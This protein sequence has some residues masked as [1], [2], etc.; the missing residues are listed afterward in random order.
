M[1]SL[2]Y[3]LVSTLLSIS[4]VDETASTI[5]AT[6]ESPT[7]DDMSLAKSATGQL[8][9]K[10]NSVLQ[11]QDDFDGE[12]ENF[13]AQFFISELA[14]VGG[15]AVG[16][17][18]P[19]AEILWSIGGNTQRRLV[20]VYN[21]TAVTG[22]AEH[23]NIRV[24]DDTILT[25]ISNQ[26]QYNMSVT[27]ARGVRGSTALPPIYQ[28]YISNPILTAFGMFILIPGATFVLPIPENAGITSV[29]VTASQVGVL[30]N[31]TEFTFSQATPFAALKRYNPMD[32]GFVPLSSQ[33]T[34]L[35]FQNLTPATSIEFSVT[36]GIDG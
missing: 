8:I 16:N 25:D 19:R 6:S 35:L 31:G 27:V 33:T 26:T 7:G 30:L 1:K 17:I 13:T 18:T 21:G 10:S 20:S 4:C 22:V 11:L 3:I 34:R 24:I 32:Y 2:N 14:A 12:A 15:G 5:D 28:T 23:F 9:S 29:M 36:W